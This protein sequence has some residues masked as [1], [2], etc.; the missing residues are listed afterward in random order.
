M[1]YLIK[2]GNIDFIIEQE[3]TRIKKEVIGQYISLRKE[4]KLSQEDI[5][6][7]TGIARPN[8]ARIESGKNIPTIEVLTKLAFALNMDLE[9]KFVE[10]KQER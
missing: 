7:T 2:Q 8:V 6:G 5:A 9:I 1:D 3:K 10:K 4:R